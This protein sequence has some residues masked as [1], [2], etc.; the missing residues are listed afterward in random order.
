[1]SKSTQ[2]ELEVSYLSGKDSE[3][4]IET[5]KV[6]NSIERIKDYNYNIKF[7]RF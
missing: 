1:M 5:N 3:K 7:L 2:L 4:I 6:I